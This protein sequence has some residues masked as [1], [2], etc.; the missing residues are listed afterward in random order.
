MHQS[1]PPLASASF[2][3]GVAAVSP[4]FIQLFKWLGALT[5]SVAAVQAFAA[6][7][8]PPNLGSGL[9]VMY[10]VHLQQQ[11]GNIPQTTEPGPETQAAAGY[12]ENAVQDQSGRIRV[13]VHL[14][15]MRPD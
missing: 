8:V 15:G 14:N 12:L 6:A 2:T 9:D 11:N 1:T 10:R 13:M 5:L 4:R 3:N 7:D